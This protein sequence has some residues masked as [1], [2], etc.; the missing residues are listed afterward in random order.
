MVIPRIHYDSSPFTKRNYVYRMMVNLK[1]IYLKI[2]YGMVPGIVTMWLVAE[3]D[4]NCDFVSHH[5]STYTHE[6]VV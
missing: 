4:V 5:Q 3:I 1:D 2:R 6:R